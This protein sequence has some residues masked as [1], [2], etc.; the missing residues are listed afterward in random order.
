VGGGGFLTMLMN[1][2]I[3]ENAENFFTFR[4]LRGFCSVNVFSY[5]IKSIMI[6]KYIRT[7]SIL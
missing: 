2:G 6:L 5:V 1:F 4:F 7:L 3:P